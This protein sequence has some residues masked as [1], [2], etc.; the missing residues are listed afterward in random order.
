M[1]FVSGVSSHYKRKK[2]KSG[3]SRKQ[4]FLLATLPNCKLEVSDHDMIHDLQYQ[5]YLIHN[6]HL[7]YYLD[8]AWQ[9]RLVDG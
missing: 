3:S 9:W 4:K 6:S 8:K 7:V 5:Y 1:L 2:N